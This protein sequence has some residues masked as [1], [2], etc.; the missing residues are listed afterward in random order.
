MIPSFVATDHES[1]LALSDWYEDHGMM[2]W[3]EQLRQENK[4]NE[5]SWSRS[6]SWSGSWS[7]SGSGS[8]SGSN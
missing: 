3:A 7:W 4:S 1:Q 5:W 2:T 6:G 8:G